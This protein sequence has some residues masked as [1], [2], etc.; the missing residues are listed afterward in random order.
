M[1]VL[2][3]HLNVM[4]NKVWEPFIHD[5]NKGV[6]K[7]VW[8]EAAPCYLD[9]CA[10]SKMFAAVLVLRYSLLTVKKIIIHFTFSDLM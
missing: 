6:R 9:V 3:K 10:S 5:R 1:K 2:Q 4:F 8:D 7:G